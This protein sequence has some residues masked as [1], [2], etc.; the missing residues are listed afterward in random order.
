MKYLGSGIFKELLEDTVHKDWVVVGRNIPRLSLKDLMKLR[1]ANVIFI[2]TVDMKSLKFA[3]LLIR[4]NWFFNLYRISK[5]FT[6]FLLKKVAK[7]TIRLHLSAIIDS[8][9]W[10]KLIDVERGLAIRGFS[11]SDCKKIITELPDHNIDV[12]SSAELQH[13]YKKELKKDENIIMVSYCLNSRL[14]SN[15]NLIS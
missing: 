8:K 15:L 2:D 12:L 11:Y 1:E 13:I 3:P 5:S 7:K 4:L 6:F 14:I 9:A 10:L